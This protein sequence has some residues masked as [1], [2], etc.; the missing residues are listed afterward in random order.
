MCEAIDGNAADE[1]HQHRQ[2]HELEYVLRDNGKI[3]TF[4]EMAAAAKAP[5]TDE[6]GIPTAR[7]MAIL[8][9]KA[10]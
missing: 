8:S 5:L 9:G 7:A 10:S 6:N 3:D 1:W 2:K 4:R